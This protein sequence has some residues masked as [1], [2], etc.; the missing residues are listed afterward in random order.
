MSSMSIKLV[1]YSS[2]CE[3]TAEGGGMEWQVA[4]MVMQGMEDAPRS[5]PN[6]RQQTGCTRRR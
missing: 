6:V 4:P 3:G 2:H 5:R 1:Y